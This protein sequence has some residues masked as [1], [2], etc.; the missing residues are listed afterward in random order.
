MNKKKRDKRGEPISDIEMKEP[1]ERLLSTQE[2]TDVG[3]RYITAVNSV[4]AQNTGPASQRRA[5]QAVFESAGDVGALLNEVSTLRQTINNVLDYMTETLK[6][7]ALKPD[8]EKSVELF[9]FI[10]ILN[11]MMRLDA[12]FNDLE[13][14]EQ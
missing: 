11:V 5:M 4:T 8:D 9:T 6:E 13:Q 10:S 1:M 3:S 7:E 12:G 14:P 2:L